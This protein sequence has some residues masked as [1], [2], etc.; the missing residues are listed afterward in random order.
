MTGQATVQDR[1]LVIDRLFD[2][3][4]AL[5]FRVWTAPEHLARWWAPQGFDLL[6]TR[7]EV[8]PGGAWFRRMRS[9]EGSE[10]VKRGVYREVVPPERLVFTYADEEDGAFGPETLVTVRFAEEG[11]G[12]RLTLRQEVFTTVA[13]RDGHGFG[14]RSALDRLADYLENAHTAAHSCT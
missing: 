11:S 13:L 14:W 5:V 4:R 10:H 1:V 2:A 12:T 7:M 9:P 6:E 3:P 8:R